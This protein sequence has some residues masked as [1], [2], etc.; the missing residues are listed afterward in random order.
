MLYELILSTL[1]RLLFCVSVVKLLK[2]AYLL[3][4]AKV[5]VIAEVVFICFLQQL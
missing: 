1:N 2:R 4:M 5:G 3:T